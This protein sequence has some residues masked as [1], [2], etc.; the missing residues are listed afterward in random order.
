MKSQIEILNKWINIM[1]RTIR[2]KKLGPTYTGRFLYLVSTIIYYSN[3]C[4]RPK[5]SKLTENE[6]KVINMKELN[7][8]VFDFVICEGMKYLYDTLNY[9]KTEVVAQ[10]PRV[11]VTYFI[12]KVI[13]NLKRFID[14]RDNDGWRD[15]N[16][17]PTYPNGTSYIDT[18]NVQDLA[19]TLA[20]HHEWTP[21]KNKDAASAQKYLTPGWGELESCENIFINKYVQIADENYL[22]NERSREIE[23]V[24]KAYSNL[25]D[26]Q[27]MVAEY[28]QGG[29]VTPPGIW[30]V[31][32]LYT[33]N[34]TNIDPIKATEFLYLL[35]K[36][37]FM[38]SIVAW[39]VKRKYM[40]ARPIQEIRLL[41]S[42]QVN[43]FDGNK[44]NNNIW[45]P[46]QQ[47]NNLTPPF[48]DYISGH[49]TFSS[50]AAVIF[51][52]YF[53]QAF[54]E[55]NFEP[56]NNEHGKMISQLLE[57]NEYENN[58]KVVMFKI[59]SSSVYDPTVSALKFPACAVKLTFNN[60]RELAN[61]SGI[62]R[63]YGGIHGNNANN[64][65]LIVGETIG[66]D[67]L[68]L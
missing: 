32:A 62:S 50:A 55:M 6:L 65:G 19:G 61:L 51:D 47:I 17:Q 31:W 8:T 37:L 12:N 30:N 3:L 18:M 26:S 7:T 44:V 52:K 49:S 5:I 59:N 45:I 14:R 53:P 25:T 29:Q 10:N 67:I 43:N 1:L 66:K 34:S 23:E 2:D 48:P 58:V 60:W 4:F 15:A 22:E 68:S 64:A 13:K 40:Q 63:I 56:F 9:P 35:N 21:L 38:A 41:E 16:I 46:F 36:T 20:K 57:N 24:V 11:N 33:I 27:R 54:S 39:N 28:F 42:Q